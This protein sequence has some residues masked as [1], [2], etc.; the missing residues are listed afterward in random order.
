MD[1]LGE[2]NKQY[3]II[4]SV[5]VLA[6]LCNFVAKY[7]LVNEQNK[8]II[9]LQ[10][11]IAAARSGSY[12][13]PAI[14]LRTV[15][16]SQDDINSIVNKIP[17][18]FSFTQYAVKLRRLMD[19][20]DLFVEKNL[21]FKPVFKSKKTEKSH[22]LQYN[23]NIAVTGDYIKI[24]KFIAD[25]LNL[26]GLAYFNSVNFARSKDNQDKVELKCKLSVFFKKGTV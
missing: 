1:I 16:T 24:K 12:I 10:Q 25:I 18:E 23:T 4:I 5:C 2:M 6:I 20:N 11:V 17:E 19:T 21:I 7:Y 3:K 8:K 22:L 9:I 26:P 14:P 15:S 13:Q